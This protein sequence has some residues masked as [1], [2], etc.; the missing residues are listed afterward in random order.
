MFATNKEALIKAFLRL[1]NAGSPD[2]DTPFRIL[3]IVYRA[4]GVTINVR[5]FGSIRFWRSSGNGLHQM[6]QFTAH[7]FTSG[8]LHAKQRSGAHRHFAST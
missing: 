3:N 1:I 4:Q 7:L 8:G 6:I 5:Q 2:S